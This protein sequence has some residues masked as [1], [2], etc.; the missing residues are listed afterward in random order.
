MI[1]RAGTGPGLG[2]TQ[3]RY[4]MFD[5]VCRSTS[6]TSPLAPE[7]SSGTTLAKG[8]TAVAAVRPV[9]A[10]P[11]GALHLARRRAAD[12]LRLGRATG[13]RSRR[14]G[15]SPQVAATDGGNTTF[16]IADTS[17]DPDTQPNFVGTS[18]AAPHA[19]AI[20]ALVLQKTRRRR[21][22]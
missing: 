5:D 15:A 2:A 22:R 6:T 4:V 16:F 18:A 9:Q 14:S 19:A 1:S 11:A 10:L 20:A 12:L 8:A 21:G 17:R 7:R 13:C 3:L